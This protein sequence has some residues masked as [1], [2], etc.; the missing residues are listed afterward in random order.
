MVPASWDE[1]SVFTPIRSVEPIPPEAWT[2]LCPVCTKGLGTSQESES[3]SL[4]L[5]GGPEGIVEQLDAWSE[6]T[7]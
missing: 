1:I 6:G 7:V 3:W 4:Q 5:L 2:Q